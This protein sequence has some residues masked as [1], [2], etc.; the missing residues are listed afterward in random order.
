MPE[1]IKITTVK[2]GKETVVIAS[3]IV[4]IPLNIARITFDTNDRCLSPPELVIGIDT[5]LSGRKEI[6][7]GSTDFFQLIH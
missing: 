2:N 6:S 4:D 3:C 1:R 7:D 5:L